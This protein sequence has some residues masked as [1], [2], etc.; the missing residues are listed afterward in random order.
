MFQAKKASYAS[1]KTVIS[2]TR[3]TLQQ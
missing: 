3:Y 2:G 1:E